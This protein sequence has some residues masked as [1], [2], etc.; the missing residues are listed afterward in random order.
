MEGE[1]KAYPFAIVGFFVSDKEATES[2]R[3]DVSPE[4]VEQIKNLLKKLIF[5]E[6]VDLAIAPF[7][8]PPDQ[9]NDALHELAGIIFSPEEK[10][11]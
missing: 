10:D 1:K 9:V 2:F 3:K 7:V 11:N 6:G 5:V 8:V 4:D